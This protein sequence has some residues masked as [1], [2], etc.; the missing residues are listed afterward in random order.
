MLEARGLGAR[1]GRRQL[2]QEIDLSVR[3][4]QILGILGQNGSGKTTLLRCLAGLRRPEAGTIAAPLAIGYVAQQFRPGQPLPV[5]D[6]VAAGLAARKGLAERITREERRDIDRTLDRVG[7]AH[8]S[9]RT[10]AQLS[11]GES[12]LV[13]IARAAEAE[14]FDFKCPFIAK[15]DRTADLLAAAGHDVIAFGKPG[16]HHCEYARAQ[17]EAAGRVGLIAEHVAE[18]REALA[19]PARNWA[20]I[21]Q[22]T[23]NTERWAQFRADLAAFGVPVRVIDTVCSDSHNRQTEAIDL[24]ARVDLVLVINDNGGSTKSVLER[25]LAVNPRSVLVDPAGE[26]PD[27]EDIESLAIVGGIHVPHWIMADYAGRLQTGYANP[28]S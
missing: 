3:A 10:V 26:L 18:I 27:L 24:A 20:C 8:L 4:G 6:F 25:C 17:A 14:V 5:A 23:A 21:G 13:L 9:N 28:F 19:E 16:N 11:G 1:F 15:S 2:W 22:V 7:A 12:R